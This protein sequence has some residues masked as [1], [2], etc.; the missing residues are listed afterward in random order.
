M[1]Q[2]KSLFSKWHAADGTSVLAELTG[3]ELAR[4]DVNFG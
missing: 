1:K 4:T 3:R 2:K